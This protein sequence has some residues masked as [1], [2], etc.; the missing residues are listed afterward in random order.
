MSRKFI[1]EIVHNLSS[2]LSYEVSLFTDYWKDDNLSV[3]DAILLSAVEDL[4]YENHGSIVTTKKSIYK[5]LSSFLDCS[6]K[7]IERFI[8][9]MINIKYLYIVP[10]KSVEEIGLLRVSTKK[11]VED[12]AGWLADEDLDYCQQWMLQYMPDEQTKNTYAELL[13]R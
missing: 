11:I 10:D 6:E 1:G 3:T 12:I 13:R 4:I 8:C 7:T 9:K 2:S 5:C